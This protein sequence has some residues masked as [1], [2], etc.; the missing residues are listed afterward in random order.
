MNLSKKLLI[1]TVFGL[2]LSSQCA[3]AATREYNLVV[4]NA[5]ISINGRTLKGMNINGQ[6]PAPKLEFTEGDD[7]IIHVKNNSSEITSLHWHGL[8]VPAEMDGVPGLNG[9]GGIKPGESFTY[10][11]HIRQNGTYWYHSHSDA[12]E[13]RGLY[14]P[15]IIYPKDTPKTPEQVILLTDFTDEQPKDILNNLKANAGHY[16]NNRRTL[17]DFIADANKFG[18]KAAAKDRAAWGKMRMDPTDIADVTGY[19]FL[20]NGKHN[21]ENQTFIAKAGEKTKLRIIN[22]SAMTYFDFRVDGLKLRVLAADGRDVEPFEVDEIRVAVAETYDVEIVPDDKAHAIIAQSMDKSGQAIAKIAPNEN[23]AIEIP[24]IGKRPILTMNDMG[25]GGMDMSQMDHSKMSPEEMQKMHEAMGHSMSHGETLGNEGGKDGKGRSFGW[26]ND[27]DPT[28]KVLDYSDLKSKN[29][30]SD[31]RETDREIIVRIGGNMEKYIWTINGQ[32]GENIPPINLKYGE[33]VKLIFKNESMMAHPMHLHGMFVQ[34]NNGQDMERLPDKHIVSVLPGQTYSVY[35]T[36]NEIGEWSFHCHLLNHMVAGMMTKIVVAKY[37]GEVPVSDHSNHNEMA[38]KG[39]KHIHENVLFHRYDLDLSK[40][41]NQDLEWKTLSWIG[42]DKHKIYLKGEGQGNEGDISLLY[43]RLIADF[44]DFQIGAGSQ[45]N[46]KAYGIAGFYGLAPYNIE[47]NAHLMLG[48][49]LA[50]VEL[51]GETKFYLNQKWFL[52]P[53]FKTKINLAKNNEFD[54]GLNE[55]KYGISANYKITPKFI[56]YIGLE[57]KQNYNS[58]FGSN[59][60]QRKI[61]M[62]IRFWF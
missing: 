46:G 9:F 52:E 13:A 60:Y 28:L 40:S 48:N 15:L 49:N 47:T 1:T 3:F 4:E 17:G 10:R 19:E 34:L 36:A 53:S 23:M 38:A 54:A 20:I 27:H 41:A 8:L 22:G 14:G 57:A 42:N 31:V 5:K 30:Q 58:K 16:N 44:W 11:F 29:I 6:V 59:D 61:A 43:S 39:V 2:S 32:S 62:G 21:N 7:A 56:P 24:K 45:I 26:G 55:I 18:L 12:Q 33:R 37:D 50:N 25:M 51:E 35:L